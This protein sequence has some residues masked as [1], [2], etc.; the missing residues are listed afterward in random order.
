MSR[1]VPVTKVG[2]LADGQMKQVEIDDHKIVVTKIDDEFHAVGG[3]CP[4]YSAP[5]A[6]GTLHRGHLICPW[7]HAVLDAATGELIE[8]PAR[9]CVPKFEV[10]VEGEQVYVL[11]P[12]EISDASVPAMAKPDT[13]KDERT[14]VIV[15][16]GAA[17]NAAAQSL[18]ENGFGGR[19][20]LITKENRGPYDRPNLSKAY[21]QGEAPQEWL[22]LRSEEFY[23]EHGIELTLGKHVTAIDRDNHLVYA[24]SDEPIE[25]DLLLLAT[26]GVPRTL[27]VPGAGLDNIFTLRSWD[28]SD[29]IISVAK[30]DA[31]AVVVGA[32]FIGMEAAAALTDRKVNVTVVA[33]ERVP[34]D[35]VFGTQ[36][37]KMFL[38]QHEK[39]GVT[40]RLGA[41]VKAF[42]GD[43][44]VSAV[45]LEGGESLA[46]DFV[47]VGIGVRPATGWIEALDLEPDG[48]VRV[49][50]RFLAADDIYAAGDIAKFP[51]WYSKREIRVEHW[52]AA[53][54]QGRI[55]GANMAGKK[56]LYKSVPFFWTRQAGFSLGYV[57]YADKW[58]EIIVDGDVD[59]KKFLAYF[60]SDDRISA[61][62]GIGRSA[63]LGAAHA[64]MLAEKLPKPSEVRKG[65]VSLVELLR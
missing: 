24:G 36:I 37:G 20:V 61:V 1:K 30:R 12:D 2:D 39:R 6:E 60:I 17:G 41:N 48:S 22:P 15:G 44:S 31:K 57:G 18:R 19:I 11:V 34:F 58:D 33:P 59:S 5:L 40:F 52:R 45:V 29:A 21:L 16:A 62:A 26:G 42:A 9:D 7:H 13:K 46:A 56:T 27:D 54:Q 35:R 28:D 64:L 32:S 47:V 4:H 14:F 8:P 3:T 63:E 49:D 38:K 23:E 10:E 65:S 43:A 25:Y 55:A 51:Y 50:D 53:E